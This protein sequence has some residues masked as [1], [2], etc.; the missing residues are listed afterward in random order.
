MLEISWTE[1]GHLRLAGRFDASQVAKAEVEFNK[2]ENSAVVD[3]SKLD[4][5][6]SAGLGVLIAAYR[7]LSEKGGNLTI[8]DMN[9]HI[10]N[11]FHFSGLDRL[12]RIE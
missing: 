9:Q 3:F 10:R 5:I 7:R 6:S 12:F 11:I 2:I 1:S 4:Y 8:R